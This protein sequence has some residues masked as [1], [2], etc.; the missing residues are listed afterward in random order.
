MTSENERKYNVTFSIESKRGNI[1]QVTY[2]VTALN[3]L[4]ARHAAESMYMDEILKGK[5]NVSYRMWF[6]RTDEI[7]TA[8]KTEALAIILLDT[9]S[10]TYAVLKYNRSDREVVAWRTLLEHHVTNAYGVTRS[11]PITHGDVA[12][13]Y[14]EEQAG[15]STI[16][17]NWYIDPTIHKCVVCYGEGQTDHGTCEVCTGKGW[18][19]VQETQPTTQQNEQKDERETTVEP[20]QEPETEVAHWTLDKDWHQVTGDVTASQYGATFMYADIIGDTLYGVSVKEIINMPEATGTDWNPVAEE[21]FYI[22]ESSYV[23]FADLTWQRMRDY[24]DSA[25]WSSRMI[26]GKE[27]FYA[28]DDGLT[29]RLTYLRLRVQEL[30]ALSSWEQRQF[31]T[32]EATEWAQAQAELSTY[33]DWYCLTPFQRAEVA[34]TYGGFSEANSEA[35]YWTLELAMRAYNI[36]ASAL[37]NPEQY[38]AKMDAPDGYVL[39]YDVTGTSRKSGTDQYGNV[40][41]E[42][43]YAPHDNPPFADIDECPACEADWSN[44]DVLT[45]CPGC[46]KSADELEDL[47]RPQCDVCHKPVY[48]GWVCLDGQDIVHASHIIVVQ[49]S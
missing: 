12:R 7:E 29:D 33:H 47:L 36:P 20:T 34:S 21:G 18:Y 26:E 23:D 15:F 8:P 19:R 39:L 48:S 25:G 49:N 37:W 44:V 6:V 41:T 43:F 14:A 28:Q 45:T 40:W 2:T 27:P 42:E 4:S 5:R 46:G 38:T 35:R 9:P 24:M 16:Q 22:V 1:E 17:L 30:A 11:F 13:N 3:P 31:T 32:E 10:Y